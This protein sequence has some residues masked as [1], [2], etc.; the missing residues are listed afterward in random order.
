MTRDFTNLLQALFWP[1]A[2]TFRQPHWQ[3]AVDVYRT[4]TGW[5]VK[6]DL[7]GVRAE[8]IA[9]E[10]QGNR[11]LVRGIRRDCF[12]EE[13]CRCYRMEIAYSHFERSI[14][15]PCDLQH[16][17]ISTDYRDGMLRVHIETEDDQ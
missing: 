5:L 2:R 11:L 14:E 16:A 3:P 9:L 15:L 10:A 7:A 12:T 4:P 8:D 13:G 17:G 6:F 1:A